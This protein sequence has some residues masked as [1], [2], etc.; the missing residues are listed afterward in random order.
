MSLNN[1]TP[2]ELVTHL[3]SCLQIADNQIDWEEKEVWAD[4]LSAMFPDHTP[5]RAQEILQSAYQAILPMDNFERKNHLIIICSKLKDH[6]NQEQLQNELA[7]KITELI[8]ADGMVLS[9]E[10]DSAAIVAEQLGITIDIS[11]D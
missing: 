2:L 7:P 9:A 11:K 10:I 5:D 3:F 8:D 4:T 1:L 6:Y